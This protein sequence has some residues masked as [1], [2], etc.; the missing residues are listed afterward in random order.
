MKISPYITIENKKEI[1]KLFHKVRQKYGIKQAY[2]LKKIALVA[3]YG[4]MMNGKISFEQFISILKIH[5]E[6]NKRPMNTFCGFNVPYKINDER[7]TLFSIPHKTIYYGTIK[8]VEDAIIKMF[9]QHV[10]EK[11]IKKEL[12]EY[13]SIIT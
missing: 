9:R 8:E 3:T 12:I 4:T 11:R 7:E 2:L 1:A 10:N 5:L 6:I 13:N